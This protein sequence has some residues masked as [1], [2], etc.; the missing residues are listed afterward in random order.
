MSPILL[1]KLKFKTI[2]CEIKKCM[3]TRLTVQCLENSEG[4]AELVEE[5]WAFLG[6]SVKNPLANT[7]ELGDACSIPEWGRSRA[8]GNG[9]PLQYSCL[10]N[11]MDRGAWWATVPGVA[12][13]D[14]TE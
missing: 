10:E 2:Y 4:K 9:N 12:Q 3:I 13:L 7:G 11:S 8:G 14:T 1:A 5:T 6:S